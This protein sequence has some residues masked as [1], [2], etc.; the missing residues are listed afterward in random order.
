MR[1]E[2]FL[3]LK[4]QMDIQIRGPRTA[5]MMNPK[6]STLRHNIIKP[7]K[8]N[9]KERISRAAK[10]KQLVMCKEAPI[11]LSADFSAEMLQARRDW[12]NI[13]KVQKKKKKTLPTKNTKSDKSIPQK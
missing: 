5:T 10:E 4:K 13:F 12:D 9:D 3:N 2:N 7:S 1:A 8:D 11:R 6:R